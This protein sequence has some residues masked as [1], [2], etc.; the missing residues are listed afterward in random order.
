VNRLTH[1]GDL[2]PTLFSTVGDTAINGVYVYLAFDGPPD[3]GSR[4]FRIADLSDY[5][6]V[7]ETPGRLLLA[8]VEEEVGDGVG[9]ALRHRRRVLVTWTPGPDRTGGARVR[10]QLG[11]ADFRVI[12]ESSRR[13]PGPMHSGWAERGGEASTSPH[14]S[15][16]MGPGLRRDDS[17]Y[18]D[19]R[20]TFN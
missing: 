16:F 6:I 1:Q 15:V 17:L 13:R 9:Q 8:V 14:P 20:A 10:T 18:R 4:V 7:S 5:R 12:S 19:Q 3:V 11:Q 2:S